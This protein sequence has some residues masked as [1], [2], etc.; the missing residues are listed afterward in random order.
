MIDRIAAVSPVPSPTDAT[1]SP[2]SNKVAVNGAE[3]VTGRPE[4]VMLVVSRIRLRSR[5]S[6]L[7]SR[8]MSIIHSVREKLEV[9]RW[10]LVMNS[11]SVESS[12]GA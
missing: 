12:R 3:R 11:V 1:Q 9:A 10:L 4:V 7:I 6:S 2:R 5:D 8:P